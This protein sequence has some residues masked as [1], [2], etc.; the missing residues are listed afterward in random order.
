MLQEE[1]NNLKQENN[2]FLKMLE[3]MPQQN[4]QRKILKMRQIGKL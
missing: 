2:T 1:N 4:I 3:F